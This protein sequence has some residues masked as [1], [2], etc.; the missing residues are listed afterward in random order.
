MVGAAATLMA[1]DRFQEMAIIHNVKG[2][3]YSLWTLAQLQDKGDTLDMESSILVLFMTKAEL[4]SVVQN[5]Q[6]KL[7]ADTT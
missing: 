3:Y 4:R 1:Q 6:L 5:E 2:K 7:F